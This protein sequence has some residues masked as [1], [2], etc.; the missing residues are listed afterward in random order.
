MDESIYTAD[1]VAITNY[2][3]GLEEPLIS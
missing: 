2:Q 1:T 3:T